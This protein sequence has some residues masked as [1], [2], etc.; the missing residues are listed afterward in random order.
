MMRIAN[1]LRLRPEWDL[2]TKTTPEV[3]R[4]LA[5][6]ATELKREAARHERAIIAIVR[7]WH[8]QLLERPGVGPIVAA[9]VLCAWSHPRESAQRPRSRCSA[10]RHPS[11]RTRGR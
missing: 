6:R 8:P 11:R 2:E 4:D 1:R 3:L 7:S 5:R 9:T 10:G